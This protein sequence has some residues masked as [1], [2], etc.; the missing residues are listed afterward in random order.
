MIIYEKISQIKYVLNRSNT[1][2]ESVGRFLTTEH[3]ANEGHIWG[4]SSSECAH[5]CI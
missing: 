1:H 5:I 3:K 2:A 4:Q